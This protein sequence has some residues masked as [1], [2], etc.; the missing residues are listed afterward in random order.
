MEITAAEHPPRRGRH[1]GLIIMLA[2]MSL[3]GALSI[4]ISMPGIVQT[5]Q[6][7]GTSTAAI[8]STMA[9]FMFGLATGQLIWGALADRWGRRQP[10]FIG[11]GL[12]LAASIVCAVAQSEE[13]LFA[14]R[15]FQG[16]GAASGMVLARA[17]VSDNFSGSEAAIIFSWQHLIMGL[18]PVAAPLIGGLLLILFGW[19][20]PFWLLAAMAAILLPVLLVKLPESQSQEAADHA[21]TESRLAAYWAVI[22]HLPLLGHVL[23]GGL[24]AAALMTWYSGASPLFEEQFGWS[25]RTTS[26]IIGILGVTLI[27]CT[28]INRRLLARHKPRWIIETA[29]FCGISVLT[30]ALLLSLLNVPGAHIITTVGIVLGIATYGFVSANNQAC[31]LELDRKRAGSAA[32]LIGAGNYGIGAIFAWLVSLLPAAQGITM[33]TMMALQLLAARL[34]LALLHPRR[35]GSLQS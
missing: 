8:Q 29:L 11:L 26:I 3:F 32:A 35:S 17:I 30:L 27:S 34:S 6:D 1:A 23:T 19:R 22:S 18:A 5:G 9:A 28:Q 12:F 33:L 24:S 4:N 21:R 14:A 16:F 25:P 2:T 10:I 15:L 31:V 20:S 7:L 13:I